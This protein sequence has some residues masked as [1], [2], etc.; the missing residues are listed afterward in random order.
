MEFGFRVKEDPTQISPKYGRWAGSLPQ[1]IEAMKADQF[2][3]LARSRKWA[4][5]ARPRTCKGTGCGGAEKYTW[6]S[7]EA[8]EDAHTV[9]IDSLNLSPTGVII[10]RLKNLGALQED[11]YGVPAGKE[12]WYFLWGGDGAAK[13]HMRLVKLNPGG[14]GIAPTMR[15]DGPARVISACEPKHFHPR[16][17]SSD[18]DLTGCGPRNADG[19]LAG[20][21]F[22][23]K[24]GAWISCS[25]GCCT[26]DSSPIGGPESRTSPAP[27]K[28]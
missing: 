28:E 3:R 16:Q 9:D 26:A 21:V 6:A 5:W 20:R 25:Q 19:S 24:A 27:I 22:H 18:A 12:E 8:I 14:W 10:G 4:G 11:T 2:L 1:S 23:T 13:P 7:A 15:V 17:R